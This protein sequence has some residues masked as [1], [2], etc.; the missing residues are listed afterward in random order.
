MENPKLMQKDTA[1]WRE[2]ALTGITEGGKRSKIN[3]A[4]ISTA[5]MK[6]GS[7]RDPEERAMQINRYQLGFKYNPFH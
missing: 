5:T 2:E 7:C 6:G 3:N 4:V 1:K